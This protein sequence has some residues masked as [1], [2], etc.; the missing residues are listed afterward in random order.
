[1]KMNKV[2]FAF[3][4]LFVTAGCELAQPF[5]GPAF[6]GG[7]RLKADVPDGTYIVSS[8]VI[9]I[10]DDEASQKRFQELADQLFA[11]IGTQPGLL[12]WSRSLIIGGNEYRTL[13]IWQDEEAMLG[14]VTSDLHSQAMAEG[15]DFSSGGAVVSW[16]ATKAELPPTF[17]EAKRRLEAEGR[18]VY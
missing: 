5:E 18:E 1:M 7:G 10:K 4:T 17:D 13:T 9:S 8:T 15:P 3:L 12:G 2:M 11:A 14:W 6:E 16:A